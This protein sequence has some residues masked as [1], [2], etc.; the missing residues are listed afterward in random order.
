MAELDT[1]TVKGF[2]SLAA[3]DQLPLGAINVVIGPNGSGKSNLI[4]FFRFLQAVRGGRL[5]EYAGKL[6]VDSL[7]YFGPKTTTRLSVAITFRGEGASYRYELH[8]EP[9]V[10]VDLLPVAESAASV[11]KG[12]SDAAADVEQL[13][14][15]GREAGISDDATLGPVARWIAN[16]M[17][18]WR[19]YH[20]HDTGDSSPMRRQPCHRFPRT[21]SPVPVP[22]RCSASHARRDAVP[23]SPVSCGTLCDRCCR[24]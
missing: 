6:G 9:G 2:K 15:H 14:R 12:D 19:L 7:L 22:G 1:I 24:C 16:Q 20:F 23:R 11:D 10:A 13:P 5:Q 18:Q 17:Q 4:A 3:I 21:C 8:L